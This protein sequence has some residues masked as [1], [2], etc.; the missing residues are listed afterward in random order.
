VDKL[1]ENNVPA[2][3][4]RLTLKGGWAVGNGVYAKFKFDRF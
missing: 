1:P 3:F 4:D 2:Y